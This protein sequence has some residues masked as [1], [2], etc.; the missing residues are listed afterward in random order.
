MYYTFRFFLSF[1]LFL[2]LL[3]L[4]LLL[5]FYFFFFFFLLLLLL[6]LLLFTF[7]YLHTFYLYSPTMYFFYSVSLF[8]QQLWT[9]NND[10]ADI[11]RRTKRKKT[12]CYYKPFPWK[13]DLPLMTACPLVT[14]SVWNTRSRRR[15]V[16]KRI[17]LK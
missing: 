14:S 7:C 16:A 3:L 10:T 11:S 5:F 6:L 12:V 17:P 9:F 1:F 15:R 2:F 13:Q 4:L 8:I